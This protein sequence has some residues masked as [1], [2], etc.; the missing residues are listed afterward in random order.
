[1]TA[2]DTVRISESLENMDWRLSLALRGACEGY[3]HSSFSE[4]SGKHSR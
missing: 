2:E 4:A 3:S 1:M